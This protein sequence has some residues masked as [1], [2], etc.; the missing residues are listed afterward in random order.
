MNSNILLR[1]ARV[2]FGALFIPTSW[3]LIGIP[4]AWLLFG[5]PIGRLLIVSHK[6]EDRLLSPSTHPVVIHFIHLTSGLYFG[7]C[8]IGLISLISLGHDLEENAT[9]L[10]KLTTVVGFCLY[11]CMYIFLFCYG[12]Y[13]NTNIEKIVAKHDKEFN[14]ELTGFG[15]L[16]VDKTDED[17]RL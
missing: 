2:L 3:Q 16:N 17:K 15:D 5:Y 6:V 8:Y 11:Y 10:P 14:K 9:A 13:F 1:S 7:T 12:I 4:V